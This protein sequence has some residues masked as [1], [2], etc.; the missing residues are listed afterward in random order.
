MK[1]LP[2]SVNLMVLSGIA[3]LYLALSLYQLDLPGL[4]YDEAFEAVPA[5]Q[6]LQGQPTT[7]F[8]ESGLRI[9]GQLYPLMTQD[10]IGAINTYLAI[11]FIILFG[12]T[13]AA[14]RVMSILI[15]LATLG[16]SYSLARYLT[17][18]RWVGLV[19]AIVLATDPTFIFWNR[20][21]IFVT[22][23]TAPIA[24]A[25]VLCW[26]QRWQSGQ[27]RWSI[28]GAFLL[29]LG[30]YAKVLFLWMI[31]A[32]AATTLLLS[33]PWLL[34]RRST[35]INLVINKETL[36]ES[37]LALI[38]SISGCWPLIIYNVQTGGT[39]T[40]VSEN[41]FTSYYGV[42]NLAIVPNLMQRIGQF[43][44]VISGGHLWYLGNIVTNWVTPLLL[45]VVVIFVVYLTTRKQLETNNPQRIPLSTIALFPILVIFFVILASIG[46]VSALWLTHFA[47]LMPWPALVIAIGSWFLLLVSATLPRMKTSA[48]L[49]IRL[50]LILL[51]ITNLSATLR[52][53]VALTKSGG[54]STHSDAIYDLSAWLDQNADG[55]VVAMDWGLAAPITYL[56][57]GRVTPVEVFGYGWQSD[58]QLLE[59]L[60]GFIAQPEALYLWRAPDEI[61]F[62]RSGEFKALYS[63]QNLEETIEEAFYEKSGRP[64]LGVTRL[65]VTGTASN[66]P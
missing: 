33:L 4:H 27:R 56:T 30:L 32:L 61:I 9:G 65:V 35:L 26:L 43:I 18:Q 34:R 8:R 15:G 57:N 41:A 16:L 28:A 17:G 66:P 63:P 24:L 14:L 60:N 53:H 54:L 23:V 42:N 47:I 36:L 62:D 58:V 7:V 19:T 52:Y 20:Q 59:R 6:L 37:S 2:N 40:N 12:P 39:F 49:I 64:I 5:V 48:R 46:T 44:T 50:G 22:A 31:A 13:P 29:G 11:P 51:V 3:A 38:A 45:V 25:A 10:Y 1:N 21:G 55:L